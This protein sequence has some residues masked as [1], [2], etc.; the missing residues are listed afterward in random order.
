MHPML[1]AYT[2]LRIGLRSGTAVPT[3]SRRLSRALLSSIS[4]SANPSAQTP[5]TRARGLASLAWS[6]GTGSRA[7]RSRQSLIQARVSRAQQ[8][9]IGPGRARAAF[10]PVRRPTALQATLRAWTVSIYFFFSHI[11]TDLVEQLLILCISWESW[12]SR[13][14]S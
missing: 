3:V 11:Q 13:N 2:G 4:I 7:G 12:T 8:T 10:C 6:A 14:D 5:V 9:Q 1:E